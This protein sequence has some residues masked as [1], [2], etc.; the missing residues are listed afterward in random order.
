MP[1]GPYLGWACGPVPPTLTPSGAGAHGR[2]VHRSR[3]APRLGDLESIVLDRLWEAG[4]GDVKSMHD[5]VGRTRGITPNTVQSAL[6]RLHR[7]GLLRRDKVGHAY[8]YAPAVSRE[9][10]SVRLVDEVVSRVMRGRHGDVLTAFV[11]F[12]ARAGT[13]QLEEL[14]RLVARRRAEERGRR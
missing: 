12:A 5:A 9:E 3:V 1:I 6:E 14:E 4:P 11:D 10:L 2:R 13:E 8:V 7:K